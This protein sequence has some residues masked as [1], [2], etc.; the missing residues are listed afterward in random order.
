MS[1]DIAR[2]TRRLERERTARKEAERL[3]DEKSLALFDKNMELEVLSQSL[4]KLVAKRTYEMQQARDEA[5]NSLQVKSDFIANMSHELRTPMNGVLGI[6]TLLSDEALSEQQLELVKVALA[7]GKHLLGVINDILD[8]SKIEANK[9]EIENAAVDVVEYFSM[10]CAPFK[11]QAKDKGI[12][13]TAE[14]AAATPAYLM[15]DA[16]RLTQVLSN[17]LSN[18]LKFTETG[19]VSV[20][21]APHQDG[22]RLSVSDTGIGISKNHLSSVFNA[23]E[24]ADTSITRVFGGTGLGMNIT[25][26]I[27]E[28][29]EG[30]ISIESELGKGTTFHV[31]VAFEQVDIEQ[32]PKVNSDEEARADLNSAR[33]LLV[34]DN[35]VNQLVAQKMLA[36]WACTVDLAQNGQIALDMLDAHP[37]SLVFMDLQMPVMGGIEAAKRIRASLAA[38]SQIPIVAMTAHSSDEHIKECQQAGM[39]DHL[40]KP[41]DRDRLQAMLHKHLTVVKQSQPTQEHVQASPAALSAGQIQIHEVDIDS[42]LARV[43]GDWPLLY[44]LLERFVEENIG[45]ETH[46][47]VL[48]SLDDQKAA[49][50]EFHRIKGGGAN[51]GLREVSK[52]AADMEDSIALKQIWPCDIKVKLLQSKLDALK[53]NLSGVDNPKIRLG[54]ADLRTESDEV[55]QTQMHKI[56]GLINKDLLSA[57]TLLNDLLTCLLS[58]P[59]LD[60][61][62]TAQKAMSRFDTQAVSKSIDKAIALLG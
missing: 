61:L 21:F 54:K 39:D 38:Y 5:L 32:H 4:E 51:L 22:Y 56:K 37:Y 60:E 31:D 13:F 40:S 52:L 2:V 11:L 45:I 19:G 35:A 18:A 58:A 34:E 27:V 53:V 10:V 48:K 36:N 29:F 50:I 23:F 3:L 6:L 9:I 8:F 41:I 46:Y 47:Q 44:S 17:L 25:K 16:F 26:R 12:D 42:S 7:S 55:I 59:M 30:A 49:S 15:F 14:V 1:T 57:E 62:T 24:Q 43:N 20:R 33:I 28:M